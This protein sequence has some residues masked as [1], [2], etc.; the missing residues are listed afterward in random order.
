M[1]EI[2]AALPKARPGPKDELSPTDGHNS[3]QEV[4]AEAGIST[5][6]ASRAEQ[7]AAVPKE[8]F[9]SFKQTDAKHK[10]H[11]RA[12]SGSWFHVALHVDQVD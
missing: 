9:E 12:K 3:K 11:L 5:Q 4:L 6:D 8:E 2:S 10:A 1:G 7:V